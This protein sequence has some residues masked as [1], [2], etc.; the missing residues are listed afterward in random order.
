MHVLPTSLFSPQLLV[1]LTPTTVSAPVPADEF[2]HDRPSYAR[3][4]R[5]GGGGGGGG[6]HQGYSPRAGTMAPPLPDHPPFKAYIGNVPYDIDEEVVEHFFRGLKI[7]DIMV[8]RHRD[9]G[10]AKGCFIEFETQKDLAN[11]LTMNGKDLLRRAVSIQVAEPKQGGGGGGGAGGSRGGRDSFF[12]DR[13]GGGSR[14][15]GAGGGGGYNRFDEDRGS[16]GRWNQVRDVPLVEPANSPR[17]R[18]KLLLQ[19]RKIVEG[20]E[21]AGDAAGAG[22]GAAKPNPF[23]AARPA[24]T[25]AKLQ[26]LEEREKQRK[27][28]AA[29]ARA[30][31]KAAVEG[32]G[33]AAGGGSIAAA[34]ETSIEDQKQVREKPE[35]P[36]RPPPG[37]SAVP[38]AGRSRGRGERRERERDGG[39]RDRERRGGASRGGGGSSRGRGE[40]SGELSHHRQGDTGRRGGRG[41]GRGDKTGATPAPAPPPPRIVTAPGEDAVPKTKVSNPF[42][43]L[44]DE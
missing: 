23:G 13:R 2:S 43:L 36:H 12:G 18:P 5:S 25:A 6:S 21:D 20:S 19:P 14:A 15:G 1:D 41:G 29:A 37:L 44:G 33:G 3:S 11:A 27:S 24:N 7:S 9:T 38:S 26:E 10:N 4:P 40:G 22:A 35:Q 16:A 8:T 17:E 39:D 34:S 32:T 42:D 30:A 31:A 28:D